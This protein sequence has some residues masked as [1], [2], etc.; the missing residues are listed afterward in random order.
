M[1]ELT[2]AQTGERVSEHA[3]LRGGQEGS[4]FS[5]ADVYGQGLAL[6]TW[7]GWRIKF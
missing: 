5:P 6:N 7:K 4:A 3:H 1:Q 2:E